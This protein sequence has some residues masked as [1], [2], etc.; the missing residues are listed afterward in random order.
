MRPALCTGENERGGFA[1][2]NVNII[3]ENG[4]LKIFIDGVQLN[5]LHSFSLDYVKGAPLLFSCV[6]DVGEPTPQR[7]R[8]MH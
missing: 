3:T 7:D 2:Q 1:M 6:A 8:V 5:G 4:K